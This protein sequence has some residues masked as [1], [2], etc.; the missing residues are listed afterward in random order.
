MFQSGH[1]P[2]ISGNTGE[3]RTKENKNEENR[4][5]DQVPLKLGQ[6]AKLSEGVFMA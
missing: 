5:W 1:G 4:L 6:T 2:K 3:T